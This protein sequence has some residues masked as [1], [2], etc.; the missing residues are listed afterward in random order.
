MLNVS[1]FCSYYGFVIHYYTTSYRQQAMETFCPHNCSGHGQCVLGTCVCD[2]GYSY[3]DCINDDAL[4]MV[5]I[6][7]DFNTPGFEER[8]GWNSNLS[9]LTNNDTCSWGQVLC[10]NNRVDE[11]DL[12]SQG[13]LGMPTVMPFYLETLD[14]R[15]NSISGTIP[16]ESWINNTFRFFWQIDLSSNQIS[17]TLSDAFSGMTVMQNMFL[18]NNQLTGP[19]YPNIWR[20]AFLALDLSNNQFTGIIPSYFSVLNPGV[21]N[22]ANNFFL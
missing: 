9:Q 7:S 2:T 5:Q 4:R 10:Y 21:V 22:T 6:L 14:L 16:A 12:A 8:L 1:V 19:L 11:L 3:L 18:Q 13:I 15:N 17:G 20:Q